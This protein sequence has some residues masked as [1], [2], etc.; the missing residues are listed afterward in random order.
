MPVGLF[1]IPAT[2]LLWWARTREVNQIDEG[3]RGTNKG[4]G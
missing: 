2:V 1:T 3:E 4:N